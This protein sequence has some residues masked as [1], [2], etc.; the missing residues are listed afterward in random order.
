MRLN[1]RPVSLLLLGA[2]S[3]IAACDRSAIAPV[4][5]H[6]APRAALGG[7]GWHAGEAAYPCTV[8]R[9]ERGDA[10]GFRVWKQEI[11]LFF[12]RA[13]VPASGATRV[14]GYRGYAAGQEL[15][16][17]AD[18]AIPA[19]DAAVR[20]AH[21]Y[22]GVRPPVEDDAGGVITTQECVN[23][24]EDGTCELAPIDATACQYGGEYPDCNSQ[25]VDNDYCGVQAA[26]G[27]GSW[28]WTGW[29]GGGNTGGPGADDE[30]P[31]LTNNEIDDYCPGCGERPLDP[32]MVQSVR[33][34]IDHVQC[35][36]MRQVLQERLPYMKVFT[37]QPAEYADP[38]DPNKV[39][40][41]HADGV[42]YIWEGM[43]RHDA[44]GNLVYDA[45]GNLVLR[46]LSQFVKDVLTHEAAH[47]YWSYYEHYFDG[48][49]THHDKWQQT[50]A[51]CGYPGTTG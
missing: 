23:V 37:Q 30:D 12:P 14:Y 41:V 29:G 33:N 49:S 39:M 17:Y 44:Q 31:L 51:E 28:G 25:P 20:R 18:C 47:A 8:Y 4:P 3:V 11:K 2:I 19:T 13:E 32:K 15:A 1:I 9:Q 43:W 16:L 6:G 38:A 24:R 21:R 48:V 46:S 42:I 10:H 26:C 45:Y 7:S 40:G 5:S 35:Q 22:F 36:S 50:M 34:A 27:G